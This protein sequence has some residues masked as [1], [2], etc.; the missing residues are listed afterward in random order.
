VGRANRHTRFHLEDTDISENS[1]SI[2][3]LGEDQRLKKQ[4]RKEKQRIKVGKNQH[5]QLGVPKCIQLVEGVRSGKKKRRL[6]TGLEPGEPQERSR[7]LVEAEDEGEEVEGRR[8]L[9]M[10]ESGLRHIVV[11]HDSFVPETQ[12]CVTGDVMMEELEASRLLKIEKE[13]GYSFTMEDGKVVKKLV[14][15]EKN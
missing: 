6:R 15:M 10:G 5:N 11:E 14:I 3:N 9:M 8:C 4:R 7:L 2:D 12:I 13:A 1:D